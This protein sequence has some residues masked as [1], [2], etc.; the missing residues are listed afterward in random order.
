MI[1]V[2]HPCGLCNRLDVITTGYVLAK[3]R[4]EANIEVFWPLDNRHMPVHFHQLFTAL[5]HGR[6]I[7]SDIDPQALQDY[8]AVTA[9]LP[10]DYRDSEFYGQMLKRLLANVVVEVKSE[11][12]AFVE[13]YFQPTSAS[14]AA[15]T[16]GIH[17]RR[18]ERPMPLCEFA[19]PLR[20][21][22]AVMKSFPPET[23]FFVS[24]DSQEAFGWLHERFGSRDFQRPKVY[25]DR[26]SLA[27]VR[28]GLIDLLL[29]SRCRA[30]LG[31]WGSSFSHIA[32]LAGTRPVL[33]LR[34]F[35]KVPANWP[36]FSWWRWVWAY[37]HLLV[38]STLWRRWLFWEVRPYVLIVPRIPTR[39][40]RV[41]RGVASRIAARP[42]AATTRPPPP[43]V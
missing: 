34:A 17:V 14:E 33:R 23:R 8:Y 29:L 21:Y 9:G 1:Q 41:V 10:S 36:R 37:R 3:Q 25:D 4:G 22:E 26:T 19:Q 16:I 30:V 15:A 7:E 31:T 12:A 6:V 13:Q 24:T 18:S 11:V 5:P 20:Y 38:E 35:P 32:A 39:C 2:G 43:S 27:G 42:A 28:E 40:L